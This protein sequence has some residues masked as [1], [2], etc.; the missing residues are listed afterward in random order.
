M[1]KPLSWEKHPKSSHCKD[2]HHCP[3]M[4][5][6]LHD[7]HLWPLSTSAFPSLWLLRKLKDLLPGILWRVGAALGLDCASRE[8]HGLYSSDRNHEGREDEKWKR[9]G[10]DVMVLTLRKLIS[11]T[12]G[13]WGHLRGA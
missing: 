3:F 5:Y 6:T 9:T 11:G 8:R 2:R 12:Q 4:M 13:D 7:V 10:E 1:T